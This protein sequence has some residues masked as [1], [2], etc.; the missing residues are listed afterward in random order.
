MLASMFGFGF[1][2]FG[3]R[4]LI[5]HSTDNLGI[6]AFAHLVA[7]LLPAIPVAVLVMR[8]AFGRN[9]ALWREEAHTARLEGAMLVARTAAHRINNSLAPVVGYA[10]LLKAT[11]SVAEDDTIDARRA[12][13]LKVRSFAERIYEAALQASAEVKLLQKIVR[14]HEDRTG[15]V[16]LLDLEA[17]TRIPTSV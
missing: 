13:H 7:A 8:F 12:S 1:L 15:V 6:A 3:T 11:G 16:A 4:V 10:E 14:L 5:G 17:S 2:P 9:V